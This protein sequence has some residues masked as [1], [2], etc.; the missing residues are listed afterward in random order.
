MARVWQLVRARGVAAVTLSWQR[1]RHG[2][3]AMAWRN[4]GHVSICGNCAVAASYYP[5]TMYVNQQY[6]RSNGVA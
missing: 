4:H 6:A 1:K 3:V 2:G 5:S